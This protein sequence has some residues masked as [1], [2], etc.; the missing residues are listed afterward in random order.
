MSEFLQYFEAEL[1]YVR[2]ALQEFAQRHPQ[3]AEALRISAGR[4]SDPDMQRV[5]DSLALVSARLHKR[6]DDTRPEI[7]IDLIRM[8]CP[9]FLLGAPSY[10][11]V[12]PDL[13]VSALDGPIDLKRGTLFAFA[14]GGRTQASFSVARDVSLY[15]I[16]VTEVRPDTAPF[17]YELPS[18]LRGVGTA[19]CIRIESADGETPLSALQI[20]NLEI[21]LS[22]RSNKRNRLCEALAGGIADVVVAYPTTHHG[23]SLGKG[24]FFPTI[25][26]E[27]KP[28][29]PE[30]LTQM[31][32]LERL[33]D[34]I[35]Y[36]D[37]GNF[38]TLSGLDKALP[39]TE[40]PSVEIRFFLSGHAAGI[41]TQGAKVGDI[42]LNVVPGINLFEI[43]SEPVRYTFARDRV[44]V[45]PRSKLGEKVEVLRID[46]VSKLTIEGEERLPEITSPRRHLNSGAICWQERLDVGNLDPSRREISFSVPNYGSGDA[47][48]FDFVASLLCS[49]GGAGIVPRPGALAKMDVGAL[50]EVPFVLLEE[51]TAPV[52]PHLGIK[53]QWDLIALING[54]FGAILESSDP[55]ESL[56]EVLHLCAPAGF[57]EAAN[58]IWDVRFSQ[59]IAPIRVGSSALLASGTEVEVVIDLEELPYPASIFSHVLNDFLGAFVSYD[60]FVQLRVRARGG[61]APLAAFERRHG[62]QM[63]M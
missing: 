7:S 36:P 2:R 16:K 10:C 43:K 53:R 60:R 20:D 38:F 35:A 12:R 57:A 19:I 52:A 41:E 24:A 18:G 42:L 4:S 47:E 1:D 15:P 48:P 14:E 6:L 25:V 9:S 21:Y 39:N 17:D 46:H 23:K 62:S 63:C 54:N 8:M 34:F 29:L 51:P 11:A 3:R 58:A 59:T 45:T 37:K 26:K 49:N 61:D 40:T 30:F 32:S 27:A 31:P 28:F 55:T 22:S 33:W 13:A 56:K 44:P 50:A 5:A